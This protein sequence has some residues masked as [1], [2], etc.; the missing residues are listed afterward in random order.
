MKHT[1]SIIAFTLAILASGGAAFAAGSGLVYQKAT[2]KNGSTLYG[3]IERN[4]GLGNLVFHSDSVIILFENVEASIVDRIVNRSQLSR[5][6]Q[7]WATANNAWQGTSPNQTL[8]LSDI[9]VHK[10]LVKNDNFLNQRLGK[11]ASN[12]RILERGVKYKYVEMT[13]NSYSLKWDD[14]VE[15]SSDRLPSTAHRPGSRRRSSRCPRSSARPSLQGKV[16]AA[17]IPSLPPAAARMD[18]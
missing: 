1:L 3:Y 9:S 14:I 13:A 2:L 12:V 6:W 8:T 5:E 15:I 18:T 7:D 17:S 11:T 16:P 4:D 10:V